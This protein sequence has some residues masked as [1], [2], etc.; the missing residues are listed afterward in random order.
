MR[1]RSRLKLTTTPD[2]VNSFIE[3]SYK[4]L[5][6]H[7]INQ[8]RKRR[9]LLTGNILLTRD[10][11]TNLQDVKK[12]KKYAAIVYMPLEIGIAKVSAMKVFSFPYPEMKNYDVYENLY[13]GLKEACKFAIKI[14]KKESSNYD[15]FYIHFKETDVPGHD[16]KPEEKKK[17]IEFLDSN[18]FSFLRGI[19]KKK[20]K[21]LITADHSTPCKLKTHS[22]DF[23]PLL[24]C[25]WKENSDKEFSERNA[26]KGELGKIYGREVLKLLD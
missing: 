16:N 24:L 12:L 26:R 21:L 6:S 8:A 23:V 5:N 22:S 13:S 4:L 18:F 20:I 11:S 9:G 25:D 1:K 2:I 14:L 15:Y 19:E 7:F 17:M 10:A 3:K